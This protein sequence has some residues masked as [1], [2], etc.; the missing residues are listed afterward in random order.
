MA[1]VPDNRKRHQKIKIAN[2]FQLKSFKI[3]YKVSALLISKCIQAVSRNRDICFWKRI[4]G[5]VRTF[6]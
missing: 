4:L 2:I 3:S 1:S 6:D 5:S